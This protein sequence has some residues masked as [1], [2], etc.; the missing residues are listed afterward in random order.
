MMTPKSQHAELE[1]DSCGN[2][3][4]VQ[5]RGDRVSHVSSL[6]KHKDEACGGPHDTRQL[7]EKVLRSSAKEPLHGPKHG[8]NRRLAIG[9]LSEAAE[10]GNGMFMSVG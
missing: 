6:R 1:D 4:P 2:V 10:Y 3:E 7:T 9:E 5:S 8:R